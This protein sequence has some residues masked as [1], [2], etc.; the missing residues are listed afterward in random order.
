VSSGWTGGWYLPG[1]TP[2]GT[3]YAVT[4][5]ATDS[6][7]HTALVTQT[8]IVDLTPP[9]PVT[10]T[11]HS[12]G[13][14]LEP[15]AT[16][17]EPSPVIT[18]TWT[19]SSDGSGI[20]GY[21]AR[22]TAQTTATLSI[23]TSAHGPADRSDPYT[24]S[25]GQKV[26]A[27]L[28]SQD[29]Y[30]LQRTRSIG[31]VYAD[32]PFTPDYL[33]PLGPQDVYRGWMAS[34]CSQVGVD[35]RISRS[36]SS[37]AA[38]SAEQ[39]FYIT[40]N[41]E[42]LRM[43]WTG[44]N[45]NR[46]GDLFIYLDTGPGGATTAYNPYGAGPTIHLPGATPALAADYLVWVRDAQTATLLRW[47]GSG[48]VA[49]S[50]LAQD[51]LY[52]YVAGLEDGLTDLHLPFGRLG[53][54][55]PATTAL[56]VVAFASEENGLYLWA[57][58]PGGN[59]L[60]SARI[61]G[62]ISGD[63]PEFALAYRYHWDALGA[64]VCPNGSLTP[65]APQY[66]DSDLHATLLVEPAGALRGMDAAQLWQWQTL[67]G[68]PGDIAWL[69]NMDEAGALLGDGLVVTFTLR[70]ENWGTVTATGALG[71]VSSYQALRLPAGTHLPA[72]RR[73]HQ[74]VNLG[75]IPPGAEAIQTFTATVDRL[76]A[77][78]YYAACAASQPDYACVHYLQ[79]ATLEV[80]LHDD[81][82]PATGPALEHL[83]SQHPADTQPPEFAGLL[84]PEYV[85][86]AQNHVL[87]G[88]AYDASGV[89]T[90]TLTITGPTG[91]P[92][93][94]R[95]PR[96]HAVRRAMD[97]RVGH[98]R[99]RRRRDLRRERPGDRRFRADGRMEQTPRL[100]R[101]QAPAHR[102]ARSGGQPPGREQRHWDRRL[103]A[104]RRHRRQPRIGWAGRVR[105]RPLRPGRPVA[106]Q[107]RYGAPVRR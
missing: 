53:I 91:L 47:D 83:W 61:V 44:A 28:T 17:R 101:G 88:Y 84:Q 41:A 46:D 66:T 13:G 50:D 10:L 26:W 76:T 62:A 49:E 102:H 99:R 85:I 5:Q 89:P 11:L 86:A 92:V 24:A 25:E 104:V 31:P 45:W 90:V 107:R 42:A 77:Q 38:L 51:G 60:N 18:L 106:E 6:A 36:A 12:A 21:Q 15:G 22:W 74:A 23:T 35:R 75:N 93:Q 59:P 57:A 16:L 73:D 65:G 64:G 56:D 27:D 3:P 78:S 39:R 68:D 43:V 71:D 100:R 82:H 70:V 55:D 105:G 1:D 63:A 79:Q 9:A 97:L 54:G 87:V 8:V 80:R 58:M 19:A 67:G 29:I 14:L 32:S 81:A 69:L 98:K 33:D 96:C 37:R 2:D 20:G 103:S 30:G 72:E 40:W 4:A 48:W 94:R 95:L 52:Q 34:G 7:G